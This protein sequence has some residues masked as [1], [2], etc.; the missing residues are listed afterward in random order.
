MWFDRVYFGD[1]KYKNIV[2][3]QWLEVVILHKMSENMYKYLH[4]A[5]DTSKLLANEFSIQVWLP[6]LLMTPADKFKLAFR[7]MS[8][9][10]TEVIKKQMWTKVRLLYIWDRDFTRFGLICSKLICWTMCTV[11][12]FYWNKSFVSAK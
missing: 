11:A 5:I 6:V 8:I 7:Y 3:L 12:F 2:L 9:L 10:E 1:H 4:N